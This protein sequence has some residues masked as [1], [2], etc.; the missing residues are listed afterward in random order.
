M[1][2]KGRHFSM[3]S[4]IRI[5][6]VTNF[7]LLEKVLPRTQQPP[8][9][10]LIQVSSVLKHLSFC[11]CFNYNKLIGIYKC[12]FSVDIFCV[13]QVKM[14]RL[15]FLSVLFLVLNRDTYISKLACHFTRADNKTVSMIIFW[16]CNYLTY[17]VYVTVRE[18]STFF[19]AV[20][21]W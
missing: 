9:K 4:S 21:L 7:G 12:N 17:S 15:K 13:L 19:G 5:L 10:L 6:A 14:S 3:L 1:C 11:N 2:Y 8:Q 16:N 18:L 20:D